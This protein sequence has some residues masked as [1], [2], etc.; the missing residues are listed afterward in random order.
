LTDIIRLTV[1]HQFRIGTL[2]HIELH[3]TLHI[4][5]NAQSSTTGPTQC[6]QYL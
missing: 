5:G 6:S 1:K 4:A 2:V 3:L